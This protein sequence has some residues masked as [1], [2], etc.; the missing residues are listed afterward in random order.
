VYKRTMSTEAGALPPP[1][2]PA[3]Y[4]RSATV[5]LGPISA[6]DLVQRIAKGELGVDVSVWHDG[7]PAWERLRPY[8]KA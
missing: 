4:A 3:I 7:L 8:K 5:Q 6:N 1:D 2:A